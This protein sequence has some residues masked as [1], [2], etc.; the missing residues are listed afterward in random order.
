VVSTRH[1]RDA[2]QCRAAPFSFELC[3]SASKR[4]PALRVRL[5]FSI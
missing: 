1:A 3:A 5:D 4:E 2:T